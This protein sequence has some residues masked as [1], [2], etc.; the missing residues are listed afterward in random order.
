MDSVTSFARFGRGIRLAAPVGITYVPVAFSLGLLAVQGGMSPW[1]VALMSAIVF[2]GASQFASLA[3]LRAATPT[4][5]IVLATLFINLRHIVFNLALLPKLGIRSLAG[6]ILIGM[7][8]T[9]EAFTFGSLSTDTGIRSF[10]GMLG[11]SGTLWVCWNGGTLA[12]ALL[13]P[14]LPGLLNDALGIMIYGLFLGL[15]VPALKKMPKAIVITAAAIIIHTIAREFLPA[16][17]AMV[18]AILGGATFGPLFNIGGDAAK[19]AEEA[20]HVD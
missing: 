1:I 11:L 6:R 9:D 7:I 13:T 18:A 17:W 20:A 16:G 14:T 3:M 12:G 8:M 4:P 19:E 5:E 2:A 10:A 15:L